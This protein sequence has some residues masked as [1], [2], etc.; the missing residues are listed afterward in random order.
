MDPVAT[1]RLV[2]YSPG[3][4]FREKDSSFDLLHQKVLLY[5]RRKQQCLLP[6]YSLTDLIRVA[7]WF[8]FK[9]KITNLGKFCRVLL[10]KILVYFITIWSIL[11]PL[12]IFYGHLVYF[13]V[14]WHIF[15][16]FGILDQEKSGNP[17]PHPFLFPQPR[18]Q[19]G[20]TAEISR[21]ETLTQK[22]LKYLRRL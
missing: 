7:R 10:W 2:K 11:R 3:L 13:V 8:V 21:C 9:P 19:N 20:P 5:T 12:Y 22:R 16:R 18:L 1:R 14:I 17:G 4:G 6:R 15:H